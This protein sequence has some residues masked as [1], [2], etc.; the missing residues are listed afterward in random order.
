M[1]QQNYKNKE[2]DKITTGLGRFMQLNTGRV[3]HNRSFLQQNLT[4]S[5]SLRG[6]S[7]HDVSTED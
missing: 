6:A 2:M 1:Q 4:S 5:L 3:V 7:S